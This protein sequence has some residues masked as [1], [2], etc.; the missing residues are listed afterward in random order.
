VKRERWN[1]RYAEEQLLWSAGPNRVLAAE[2]AELEP[3]RALDLACGEGRNAIWLAERGWRVTA[4]DFAD[5]ALAKAARIA[6]ERGVDVDFVHADLLAWEPPEQ[7]FELVCVLYLQ[8]PAA[9]RRLVLGR[10]AAAVAPGGTLLLVAHDL[11]NLTEGYGGPDNP[12]VLLTPEDV[13][14]ELPGLEIERA[15]R[16][17]RDVEGADRP[18]IDAL[19]RARRRT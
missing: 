17:L 4:V 19:V 12:D 15:E 6:S 14:V 11:S 9:D 3:G 1:R 5:V 13:A 2:T 7:S 18:A 16:I 10:A 8:L